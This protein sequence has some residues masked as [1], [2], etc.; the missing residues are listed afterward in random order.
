MTTKEAMGEAVEWLN[1]I[2]HKFLLEVLSSDSPFL[3]KTGKKETQSAIDNLGEIIKIIEKLPEAEDTNKRQEEKEN[4][5]PNG[6]TNLDKEDIKK[7][8]PHEVVGTNK[9]NWTQALE[10]HRH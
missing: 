6:K 8:K 7:W 3:E 1:I 2:K 5:I 4:L 9:M 10:E